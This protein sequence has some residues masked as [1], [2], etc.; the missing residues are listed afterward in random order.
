MISDIFNSILFGELR[1][2]HKD[3]SDEK[4]ISGILK[5]APA[6][7]FGNALTLHSRIKGILKEH[8]A[9]WQFPENNLLNSQPLSIEPIYDLTLP[10]HFNTATNFYTELLKVES[11]RYINNLAAGVALCPD[12]V[13]IRYLVNTALNH[14]TYIVKNASKELTK[15]G[16]SNIPDYKPASN[17][18]KEETINRNT[19][20]AVYLLKLYAIKLIFEVQELYSIYVKSLESYEDFFINTLNENVPEKSFLQY[21]SFY[22]TNKVKCFLSSGK[23]DLNASLALLEEMKTQIINT[24]LNS[25]DAV[26]AIENYIFIKQ[27]NIYVEDF[28]FANLANSANSATFFT[29]V[30]KSLSELISQKTYGHERFEI[31]TEYQD[32]IVFI[33]ELTL[34]PAKQSASRKLHQWLLMQAEA[35]R[36][37]MSNSFAVPS[38]DDDHA[39]KKSKPLPILDK[40]AINKLKSDAQEFLKHFSGHNVHQ[41]II[42]TKPD[43]NRLLEYTYYLIEHEKLPSEI[44]Q[45][46]KIQ[47]SANHIRYTYYLMHQS[48]YG[49]K[50]IKPVWIEFLQKI[51]FQFEGQEWQTIKTKFS[52]KPGKYDYDIKSMNSD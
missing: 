46:P 39:A 14:L 10:N 47:L 45:I 42:M 44:K 50:E 36:G 35:Y 17:L 6:F 40:T 5:Q 51:F 38:P 31:I 41:D 1:P 23:D 21:S 52:V 19:H 20:Y 43:F 28:D 48:F 26:T 30:K 18:S 2:W 49:T 29:S 27:F 4:L 32:K 15:C 8:P 12:A 16:F 22:F 25:F 11:L 24:G 33:K 7:N 3:F 37:N 9:L 13:D 34:P